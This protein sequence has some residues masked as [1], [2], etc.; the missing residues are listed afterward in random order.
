MRSGNAGESTGDP[1]SSSA[2]FG[3]GVSPSQALLG[4]RRSPANYPVAQHFSAD[5]RAGAPHHAEG[6]GWVNWSAL[7]TLLANFD[8]VFAQQSLVVR[9]GK[10][11]RPTPRCGHVSNTWAITDRLSVFALM[12]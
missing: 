5:E 6:N 1:L 11:L 7:A 9:Y 3:T 8:D 12:S 10:L 2:R 4:P